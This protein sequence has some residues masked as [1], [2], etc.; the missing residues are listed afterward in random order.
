MMDEYFKSLGIINLGN[1]SR[2]RAWLDT[3]S[4]HLYKLNNFAA[5]VETRTDLELNQL[6]PES[7][8][9]LFS[10][11]HGFNPGMLHWCFRGPALMQFFDDWNEV[12]NQIT[13]LAGESRFNFPSIIYS[14][15]HIF[16]HKDRRLAAVNVGLY[17][18]DKSCNL[19]W[20]GRKLV[21]W[22]N[23]DDNEAIAMRVYE[24]DHSVT[25]DDNKSGMMW[26][27]AILTWDMMT[28]Y[29]DIVSRFN[30]KKT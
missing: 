13:S 25:Q 7:E 21:A 22:H 15:S 27:R 1:T 12:H 5:R 3:V 20:E 8:D 2:I 23:I 10:I 29:E 30:S 9:I 28:P 6:S 18:S 11:R 17:H 4:L 19:Y 16:R 26:P 24:T 14:N